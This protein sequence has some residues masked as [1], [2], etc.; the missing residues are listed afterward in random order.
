[1]EPI[2]RFVH[3]TPTSGELQD[4]T[5]LAQRVVDQLRHLIM[6]GKLQPDTQLPNETELSEHL[7]VSRSTIR[8]ALII[9]EQGGFVQRRW[10]VG[11]FIAKD[12]PTYNNL[13][14]NSGVTQLIRSS[15]AEPGF[16]EMLLSVRPAS[17]HIANRLSIVPGS[18][19]I[20]LERVRLANERRVVFM[21]DYLPMALFNTPEGETPLAEIEAYLETNQSMYAF[22]HQRLGLDIHHGIAGIRPLTAESYL[23]EKLQV[24]RGSSLLHIEQVDFGVNGD[25]LALADEY[26]VA[27]A[28]TFYVYRS[29]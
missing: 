27:D 25:P 10:G 13:N 17:E 21:Q 26:Y 22:M 19:V 15:G 20:V 18:Q 4:S 1:M 14:I 28:F 7:N 24:P 12:P 23:A 29:S 16:A 11:T 3:V 9:L 6:E 5:T 8:S 2:S